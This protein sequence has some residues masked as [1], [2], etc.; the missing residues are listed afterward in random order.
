MFYA[1]LAS[2]KILAITNCASARTC[3]TT[4][5][6]VSANSSAVQ[7]GLQ[8][9]FGIIG[10]VALIIIIVA[11]IQFVTSQGDPNSATRARNTVIYAVI[12]LIIALAAEAIVTFALNRI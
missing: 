12:G 3:D 2:Q 11:A 6:E 1:L 7:T 4:L 9:V 5:P 10:A 8:L